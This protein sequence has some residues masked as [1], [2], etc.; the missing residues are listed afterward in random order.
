VSVAQFGVLLLRSIEKLSPEEKAA[1]RAKILCKFREHEDARLL[2]M[3]CS[4]IVN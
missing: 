2:A 3:A 1:V 4:E